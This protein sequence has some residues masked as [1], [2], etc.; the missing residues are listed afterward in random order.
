MN[1]PTKWLERNRGYPPEKIYNTDLWKNYFEKAFSENRFDVCKHLILKKKLPT[2]YL[3]SFCN[4]Y[5]SRKEIKNLFWWAT[6]ISNNSKA[7]FYTFLLGTCRDSLKETDNTKMSSCLTLLTE[8]GLKKHILG[9]ASYSIDEIHNTKA[10]AYCISHYYDFE[11]YE[12]LPLRDFHRDCSEP[13]IVFFWLNS[14]DCK[15]NKVFLPPYIDKCDWIRRNV[16]E[17]LRWTTIEEIIRN[18]SYIYDE[19]NEYD[20]WL[21]VHKYIWVHKCIYKDDYFKRNFIKGSHMIYEVAKI[22]IDTQ[23]SINFLKKFKRHEMLSNRMKA[24]E[25]KSLKQYQKKN[26][27]KVSKRERKGSK[28]NSKRFCKYKF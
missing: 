10:F 15:S 28:K 3:E 6:R 23:V 19:D 21:R 14:W 25:H 2:F 22:A 17:D 12:L 26:I 5:K 20:K 24:E 18:K 13:N 4:L 16:P 1:T 7:G 27:K 9:F 11:P 8:D